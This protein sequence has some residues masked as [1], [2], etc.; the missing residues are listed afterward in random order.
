MKRLIITWMCI[1]IVSVITA[2]LTWQSQIA[3]EIRPLEVLALNGT[4]RS[5]RIVIPH[6]HSRSVPIVFAFHGDGDSVKSMASY[7][8]LDR[9][10]ADNGFIL[11]YPDTRDARW[12][13]DKIK[14]NSDVRFFDQLLDDLSRQYPI[15]RERVFVVG[16]SNGASFVQ[17]LMLTRPNDIAAV[18]AH[19]GVRPQELK[20]ANN[21]RP[22]M[23]VVGDKDPAFPTMQSDADTYRSDGHAVKFVAVPG[24]KHEWSPG[25]NTE[26]WSFLSQHSARRV[27]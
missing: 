9:L 21:P 2:F 4:T 17:L 18:V 14:D 10:A 6:T 11:A 7:S 26:I 16:M 25:H 15:D 24:L 27:P 23:L 5:Y 22:I 8:Q 1:F 19:S 3:A 13:I 12:T 20:P